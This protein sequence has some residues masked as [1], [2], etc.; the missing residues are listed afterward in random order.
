MIAAEI[1]FA[2]GQ[3]PALADYTPA[4]IGLIGTLVGASIGLAF[5]SFAHKEQK[6]RHVNEKVVELLRRTDAIRSAFVEVFNDV[7]RYGGGS[8]TNAG[9]DRRKIANTPRLHIAMSETAEAKI[10]L[11][12]IHLTADAT[13]SWL[14]RDVTNSSR[15]LLVAIKGYVEKDRPVRRIYLQN[16]AEARNALISH[17][18]PTLPAPHGPRL[19]AQRFSRWASRYKTD[20]RGAETD[21]DIE[22]VVAAGQVASLKE[23]PDTPHTN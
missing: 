5:N 7:Q 3:G 9:D 4:A 6:R 14:A 10:V 19:L 11:D 13:T 23:A 1:L 15:V 16:Y 20:V 2:S 17:L 12:Y 18:S 8:E 21:P 22:P